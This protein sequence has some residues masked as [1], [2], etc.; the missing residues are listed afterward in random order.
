M[1]FR[2]RPEMRDTN[3]PYFN[4]TEIVYSKP[5]IVISDMQTIALSNAPTF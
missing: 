3:S 5:W 1:H 2:F 4:L